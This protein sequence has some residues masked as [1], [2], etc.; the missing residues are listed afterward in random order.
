MVPITPAFRRSQIRGLR[1]FKASSGRASL[2]QVVSLVGGTPVTRKS[3]DS[4]RMSM[5][6]QRLR[7]SSTYFIHFKSMKSPSLPAVA[8]KETQPELW[9][10]PKDRREKRWRKYA[11]DGLMPIHAS[12]A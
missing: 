10:S 11:T 12:Q 9:F 6:S 5:K 3:S 4:S 7:K 8:M 2:A 1:V